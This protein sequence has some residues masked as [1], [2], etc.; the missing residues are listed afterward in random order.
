MVYPPSLLHA[1]KATR[2]I[3]AYA[4]PVASYLVVWLSLLHAE[5]SSNFASVPLRVG[6]P[7]SHLGRVRRRPPPQI[8]PQLKA[9][10]LQKA[11][12]INPQTHAKKQ[13]RTAKVGFPQIAQW[14]SDHPQ[15]YAAPPLLYRHPQKVAYRLCFCPCFGCPQIQ[16]KVRSN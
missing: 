11:T 2:L 15:G 3:T 13:T 9:L 4:S 6:T 8:H 7:G 12:H 10:S 14:S 16:T 1:A 5:S